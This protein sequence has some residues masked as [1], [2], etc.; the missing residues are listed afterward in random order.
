LEGGVV[1]VYLLRVSSLCEI[2]T[3]SQNV[4][5]L[6]RENLLGLNKSYFG[7]EIELFYPYITGKSKQ[8][9]YQYKEI[10]IQRL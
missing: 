7:V 1:K 5:H 4:W 3:S 10:I 6:K 2:D 9:A 8:F